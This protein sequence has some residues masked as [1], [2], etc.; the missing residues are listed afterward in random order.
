MNDMKKELSRELC[1]YKKFHW[2][3]N[4][5]MCETC[6]S[7]NEKLEYFCDNI[8]NDIDYSIAKVIRSVKDE[9]SERKISFKEFF[10]IIFN[11][12]KYI[13]N[14]IIDVLLK[15]NGRIIL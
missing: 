3:E 2:H 6:K 10:Y 11:P 5:Y 9:E 13:M 14:R 1:P 8:Y 4:K 15:V 12:N 7:I